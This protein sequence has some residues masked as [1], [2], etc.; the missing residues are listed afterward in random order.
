M[1]ASLH[2]DSLHLQL[3]G[4][5]VVSLAAP[6]VNLAGVVIQ[7]AAG[8]NTPGQGTLT[9]NNGSMSWQADNS[10]TNGTAASVGAGGV[11]VLEDGADISRW[12]RVQ[13]L[14]TYL[15]TAA[16]ATVA[17]ADSY[18]PV[19]LGDV[20]AAMAAT[21]GTLTTEFTI[22]NVGTASLTGG[23]LWIDTTGSGATVL[24]VSTDGTNFYA[25]S[26]ATDSHAMTFSLAASSSANL[27]LKRIIAASTPASPAQLNILQASWTCAGG[28]YAA[29]FRGK[30][31]IFNAAGYRFYWSNSA[32]PA[33][34]TSPQAT[35]TT[36]PYTT[37]ATFGNGTWFLSVSY[38]DGVLDSG[39]LP[40]GPHGETYQQVVISGG[41]LVPTAPS[42][43]LG[44]WLEV[45]SGGVIRIH[46]T[47]VT[48]TDGS[49]A[50]TQWA[51]AYTTD[52]SPPPAGSPSIHV[53]IGTGPLAVLAYD[54]PAQTGGT[55]VK[56]ELQTQRGTGS[57]YSAAA[58]V[59]SAVANTTGPGTPLALS[60]WPGALPAGVT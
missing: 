21:G 45:R 17:T 8:R 22:K 24:T 27:W 34:G 37:T 58:P 42:M 19:G 48:A 59:L 47:Y 6:N 40:L 26:S 60:D 33:A 13:T 39:F 10:T 41:A 20:V 2:G 54:L 31:R 35:S 9:L 7:E 1:N 32:P 53:G 23:L 28:N 18:N 44:P 38:F 14:A 49:N 30:Y 43:P 29:A 25:P 51:I 36:L 5:S 52:G 3:A 12:I 15:P 11:F 57:I 56:V 4:V 55:T 50:A 16:Q 46:A